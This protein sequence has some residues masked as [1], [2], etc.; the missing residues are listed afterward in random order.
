MHGPQAV[1]ALRAGKHVFSAVPAGVTLEE[2]AALVETVRETGLIY[3]L[4]ETSYYY[5][6]TLFCRD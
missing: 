3:M 5:P 2:V 4:A 1:Q 6:S